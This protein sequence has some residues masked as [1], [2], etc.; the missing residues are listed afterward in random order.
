MNP[1]LIQYQEKNRRL[2]SKVY[3]TNKF[4]WNLSQCVYIS[5]FFVSFASIKLRSTLQ[6]VTYFVILCKQT[7]YTNHASTFSLCKHKAICIVSQE[8][9]KM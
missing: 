4:A 9:F 1:I 3:Q 8:R 2:S 6:S 7:L 5:L